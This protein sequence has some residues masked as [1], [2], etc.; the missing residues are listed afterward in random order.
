VVLGDT[1]CRIKSTWNQDCNDTDSTSVIS[2]WPLAAVMQ[3][4][5]VASVPTAD[6]PWRIEMLDL[7]DRL[8]RF[9]MY[10]ATPGA[11]AAVTASTKWPSGVD[12]AKVTADLNQAGYHVPPNQIGG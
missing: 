8:K 3:R 2:G 11:A 7:N 4:V 1:G 5:A 12:P 6:S 9:C 10:G